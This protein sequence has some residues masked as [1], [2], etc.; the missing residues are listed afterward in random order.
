[1][2][3]EVEKV[4]DS[5]GYLAMTGTTGFQAMVQ[6]LL[7][8]D[9]GEVECRRLIA[10]FMLAANKNPKIFACSKAS[11]AQCLMTLADFK[12]SPLPELAEAY[13]IPYG[14]DLQVN[15]GYRGMMKMILRDPRIADIDAFVVRS[16][17]T[18][19]YSLGLSP[20]MRHDVCDGDRGE[21]THVYA[22]AT[23]SDGRKKFLVMD[24]AEIEAVRA[25]SKAKNSMAWVDF[26]SEMAR[27]K[28]I[29]RFGKYLPL[30]DDT[31]ALIL[32]DERAEAHDYERPI[33]IAKS[34]KRGTAALV[35][36]LEAANKVSADNAKQA[37]PTNTEQVELSDDEKADIKAEEY[38]QAEADAKAAEIVEGGGE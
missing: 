38:R 33:Y 8:A 28:A 29:R 35:E 36:Q 1:M 6:D 11:V 5:R 15:I 22:V 25:K 3:N 23:F 26:Y 13:L 2:T 20:S 7:P 21:L 12:L 37:E 9:M 16:Q 14:Q 31:S 19:S 34:K 4:K 17:D 24:K 18:F 27:A 32:D 30:S 10:Q